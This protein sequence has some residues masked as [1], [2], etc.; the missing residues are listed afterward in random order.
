MKQRS[1]HLELLA[2]QALTQA[3]SGSGQYK[4][5]YISE[6][7]ADSQHSKRTADVPI[8]RGAKLAGA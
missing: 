4:E 7:A 2:V 5:N 6:E 1:K 3:L 8:V